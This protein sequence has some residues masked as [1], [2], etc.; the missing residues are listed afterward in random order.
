VQPA[1]ERHANQPS[2]N[3]GGRED[4]RQLTVARGLD[5]EVLFLAGV[6]AV[7]IWISG[8]HFAPGL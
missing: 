5:P 3:K 8:R 2:N 4:E 1:V 6:L 7:G